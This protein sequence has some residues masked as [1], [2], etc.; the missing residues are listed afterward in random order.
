MNANTHFFIKHAYNNCRAHVHTIDYKVDVNTL[1]RHG[2]HELVLN[3]IARVQLTTTKPLFFDAYKHNR[4]TGAFVLIDPLT[5]HTAAVGMIIGKSKN[6]G[7]HIKSEGEVYNI[8][9]AVAREAKHNA[10]LQQGK[11]VVVIDKDFI[12]KHLYT[13]KDPDMLV[14][15]FV[16]LISKSGADVIVER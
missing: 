8:A 5:H 4:Q 11:T 15:A 13:C 2:T 16:E 14:S 10:L 9:D 12:N 6:A 1:E 7:H 3:D